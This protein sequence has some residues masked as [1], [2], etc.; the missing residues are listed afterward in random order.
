MMDAILRCKITGNPCG[1]D[2][3]M[4]GSECQ[5]V[6][7]Q[8]WLGQHDALMKMEARRTRSS[9]IMVSGVITSV[10]AQALLDYSRELHNDVATTASIS[11]DELDALLELV[12]VLREIRA[13]D[14]LNQPAID[15]LYG[16]WNIRSQLPW[17]RDK[18]DAALRLVGEVKR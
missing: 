14:Y 7:C 9:P 16:N 2:T 6:G 1:T 10:S 11:L 4:R 12:Q 13:W 15:L 5:C 18:I 8:R 3:W 17:L